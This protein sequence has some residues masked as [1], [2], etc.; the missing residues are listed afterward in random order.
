MI[1]GAANNQS[2]AQHS[3]IEQNDGPQFFLFGCAVEPREKKSQFKVRRRMLHN[4]SMALDV[5]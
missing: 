2:T 5:K 1:N 3:T 4:I